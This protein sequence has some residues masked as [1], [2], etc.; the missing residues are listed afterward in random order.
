MKEFSTWG[1]KERV[2][3]RE[4][5]RETGGEGE[6]G[7][8]QMGRGRGRKILILIRKGT[9]LFKVWREGNKGKE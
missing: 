4:K 6:E 8:I 5:E 9:F 7:E 2:E 1:G 3:K